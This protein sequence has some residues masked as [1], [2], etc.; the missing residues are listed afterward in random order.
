MVVLKFLKLIKILRKTFRVSFW[1]KRDQKITLYMYTNTLYMGEYGFRRE[2]LSKLIQ[3]VDGANLF[4]HLIVEVGTFYLVSAWSNPLSDI[5]VWS[6]P[7]TNTAHV[8]LSLHS[9]IKDLLFFRK[10]NRLIKYK[11]Y[12]T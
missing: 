5:F 12:Y 1:E 9:G 3:P 8:I 4:A 2:I 10:Q 6:S 7:A 11:F